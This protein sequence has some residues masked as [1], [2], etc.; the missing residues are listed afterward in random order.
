MNIVERI[1]FR[2]FAWVD[3]MAEFFKGLPGNISDF[4]RLCALISS[5]SSLGIRPGIS[6]ARIDEY[7]DAFKMKHHKLIVAMI[8]RDLGMNTR[9]RV[10]FVSNS[11]ILKWITQSVPLYMR[12]LVPDELYVGFYE[13]TKFIDS[14]SEPACI[15][16]GEG[17]PVFGT[18]EFRS[19]IT[20]MNIGETMR[21]ES[22]ESF[23]SCVAHELCHVLLFSLRHP[24]RYSEVAT[25][26][27][28][29][30]LGFRNVARDG[31]SLMRGYS[32]GYLSDWQFKFA[33]HMLKPGRQFACRA[34]SIIGK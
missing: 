21:Y 26:L 7:R 13:S 3:F 20:P 12:S 28:V 9:I 1:F 23:V 22:A 10:K 31:R 14:V 2:V 29:L 17:T 5:V 16:A 18:D 25:D 27:A 4:R 19:F 11:L 24:S 33:Y 30:A 15:L 8:M 32:L 34:L 6:L